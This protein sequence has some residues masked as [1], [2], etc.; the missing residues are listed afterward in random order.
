MAVLELP[1][2]ALRFGFASFPVGTHGSRTMMLSELRALLAAQPLSAGLEEYRSAAVQHN[3]LMKG[4]LTG[5][6]QVFRSLRELY[7]LDPT[8]LLFRALRELWDWEE[9]AQPLLAVLSATARDPVLRATADL[10]LDTRPGEAVTPRQ[11][12][13]AIAEAYP[14]RYSPGL[15][16]HMGRNV[17]S[18]W[19]QSGHLEGHRAKTRSRAECT[20][21]ATAYALLMGYLCGQ[22]GDGLL[23]GLWARLLDAPPHQIREQA[24]VASQRGWIDYRYAGAV[25]DIAFRHF[26]G[27]ERLEP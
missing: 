9:R 2:W 19:R 3:V 12:S 13:Q 21:A 20:P 17:A 27:D 6:R 8:V 11:L 24:V 5:R 4:T 18:T 22:R 26:L 7:A 14:G 16:D 25:T 10:I 23:S 1:E 15:L